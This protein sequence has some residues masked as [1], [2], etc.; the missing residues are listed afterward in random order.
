MGLTVKRIHGRLY[1][2]EQYRVD[3]RL[4]TKYIGP[5][6][7]MARVYQLY[8]SLGKVERLSKR[9]LR[10]LARILLQEYLEALERKCREVKSKSEA[11]AQ[12]NLAM[13]KWWARGDLNPGPPPCQGGVLTRLDDGPSRLLVP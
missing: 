1:V 13:E 6:E 3:G 9:D 5:L 11:N 12:P 7:E 4:V 8:K 2:Y 10:R